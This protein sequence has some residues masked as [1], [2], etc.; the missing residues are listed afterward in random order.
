MRID[1]G[2]SPADLRDSFKKASHVRRVEVVEYTRAED[3]IEAAVLF[4]AEMANIVLDHFEIFQAE[5]FFGKTNLL[6]IGHSSLD[7]DDPRSLT[8]EFRSIAPFETS[9]VEDAQRVKRLVGYIGNYLS[10]SY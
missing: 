4:Q 1:E 8:G 6:D 5:H 7:P 10:E 3:H 9:K 2:A